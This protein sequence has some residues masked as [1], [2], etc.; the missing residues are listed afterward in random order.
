PTLLGIARPL[1]PGALPDTQGLFLPSLR[2]ARG[3]WQQ[4]L[5]SL[6]Q[7]YVRGAAVDWAAFDRDEPR[8]RIPLPTYPF[9]R[10]SFWVQ[11]PR[12]GRP[13]EAATTER[14]GHP[15]LGRRLELA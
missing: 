14:R 2:P 8:R 13:A 7:L 4:I 3:D 12:V 6:A 10:R 15:L 5:S 11:Q 9:Q 1:L